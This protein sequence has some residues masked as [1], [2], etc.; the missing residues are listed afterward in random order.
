M[1]DERQPTQDSGQK[2]PRHNTAR[3]PGRIDRRS[4]FRGAALSPSAA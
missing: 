1:T 3:T 4:F 2:H